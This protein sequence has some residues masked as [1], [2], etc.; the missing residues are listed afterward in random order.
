M[1]EFRESKKRMRTNS[2]RSSA[3][4]GLYFSKLRN[5]GTL[6]QGVLITAT[7][8]ALVVACAW[9]AFISM[10]GFWIG[11]G[12]IL[13]AFVSWAGWRL[14]SYKDTDMMLRADGR[15]QWSI[16]MATVITLNP[17]RYAST[18]RLLIPKG[19]FAIL[20]AAKLRGL[21]GTVT[22][23]SHLYGKSKAWRRKI[24][25]LYKAFPEWRYE[26]ETGKKY[27]HPVNAFWLSVLR[28]FLLRRVNRERLATGGA[29]KQIDIGKGRL[30]TKTPVGTI[31]IIIPAK[32]KTDVGSDARMYNAG[33]HERR[34]G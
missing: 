20:H 22:L 3:W 31:R 2:R 9:H 23:E 34:T 11:L 1:Q 16:H 18:P 13:A 19:E 30:T 24:K 29:K 17:W 25:K 14:W 33:R 32:T 4:Q 15:G 10:H 7:A 6:K 8:G 12:L 5:I 28:G 27:L 26:V 21:V